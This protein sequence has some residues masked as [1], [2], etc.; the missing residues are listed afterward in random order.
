[1]ACRCAVQCACSVGF[2]LVAAAKRRGGR[3]YLQ[4]ANGKG[5]RCQPGAG[6]VAAL[7]MAAVGIG[8]GEVEQSCH[9]HMQ[10]PCEAD[11]AACMHACGVPTTVEPSTPRTACLD[12]PHTSTPLCG[13][14]PSPRWPCCTLLPRSYHVVNVGEIPPVSEVSIQSFKSLLLFEG[15]RAYNVTRFKL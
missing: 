2:R 12:V 4:G 5:P 8:G 9:A 15:T 13:P 10:A 1:M 7:L 6:T 14:Q 11:N 3:G